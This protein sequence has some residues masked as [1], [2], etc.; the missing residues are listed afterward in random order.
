MAFRRT[1]NKTVFAAVIVLLLLA[2]LLISCRAKDSKVVVLEYHGFTPGDDSTENDWLIPQASFREQMEYLK[3]NGYSVIS[4]HHLVDHMISGSPI[5]NRPVVL[6]FDDGYLSNYAL[7]YPVL[8]KLNFP[9]TIF[10]IVSNEGKMG[11][12]PFLSW[13]EMKEMESGGLIDIQ[14]HTYGLHHMQTIA[15]EANGPGR[16]ENIPAA[17]AR[18]YAGGRM[19]T[20]EAYQSRILADLVN[21]RQV[22]EKNLHN[23]VDVLCW[24]FGAY[25]HTLVDIA[26]RAGFKYMVTTME[27]YNGYGDSPLYIYR[28]TVESNMSMEDFI[29]KLNMPRNNYPCLNR[30]KSYTYYFRGIIMNT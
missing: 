23:R 12:L 26:R 11:G 30:L 24:P 8:K 22:I 27:G 15:P 28:Q 1:C 21:S 18:L 7:A 13:G 3:S 16:A 9:A 25:N 20:K 2:V 29:K 19:E 5:P 17:L 14:S 4:L 6:T 10:L